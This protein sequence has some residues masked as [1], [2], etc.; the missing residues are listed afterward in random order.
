MKKLLCWIGWHSWVRYRHE[1]PDVVMTMERCTECPKVRRF[2]EKV[3]DELLSSAFGAKVAS[4]DALLE[5]LKALNEV[6][7]NLLY[8]GLRQ[9][10]ER[11]GLTI[12]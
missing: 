3:S 6:D 9:V 10:I 5:H 11:D 1:D 8:T 7:P 2:S 4:N 12:S